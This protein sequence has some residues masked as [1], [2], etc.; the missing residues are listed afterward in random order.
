MAGKDLRLSFIQ[1]ARHPL[2]EGL[3]IKKE[4]RFGKASIGADYTIANKG[5]RT[6]E[7]AFWTHHQTSFPDDE[8]KIVAPVSPEPE[9]V[10]K[11]RASKECRVDW[12]FPSG[13][14]ACGELKALFQR[15]RSYLKMSFEL[16][17]ANELYIWLGDFP[18]MECM[19][20]KVTLPPGAEWKTPV[21]YSWGEN[22]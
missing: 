20:K 18:T 8:V 17:Q 9:V 16:S 21:D 7:F 10:N 13:R 12:T 3:S 6:V 11:R 5:D 15:G 4:Y 19:Y 14:L 1:E 2:L 22:H